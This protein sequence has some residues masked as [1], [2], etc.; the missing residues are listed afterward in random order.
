MKTLAALTFLVTLAACTQA[1]APVADTREADAAAIR[2]TEEAWKAA[3]STKVADNIT[4]YWAENATLMAPGLPAVKGSAAIKPVI[5]ELV[6]DPNFSL[7]LQ[8]VTVEASR[9]GDFGYTQGT[10]TVTATDPATKKAV[11]EKGK[12]LTLYMKQPDGSWKS[13]Q[14]IWNADGPATPVEAVGK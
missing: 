10:Y 3:W 11:T 1:P 8:T 7:S 2:A 5:A 12:Y 9:G 4:P 6:A 13:V 14:D